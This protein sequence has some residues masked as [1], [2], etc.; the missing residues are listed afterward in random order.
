MY[1]PC[2]CKI[3]EGIKQYIENKNKEIERLNP[4]KRLKDK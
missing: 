4:V 1:H 3:T 2:E